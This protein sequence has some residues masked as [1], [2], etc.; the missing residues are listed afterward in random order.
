MI[1]KDG[2]RPNVGIVLCNSQDQ[3]LWARRYGRDGW[4]FPQ[5][6]IT[7]KE[8]AEEAMYREL[9]EEIGLLPKHVSVQGRT[10]EW[11][12]YDI[13]EPHRRGN[14]NN[15]GFKGQKQLWFLLRLLGKDDDVRLDCC[16]KP[17]FD[18]WKWVDYWHPLEHIIVFKRQVY[19]QALKELEP[20]LQVNIQR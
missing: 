2:Y 9:Y 4:Q 11:L 5:G 14:T 19:Q 16:T 12:Y 13:P 8:S 10:R 18:A 6:G 1:D 15:S 7:A 3:V 17:E 20:L